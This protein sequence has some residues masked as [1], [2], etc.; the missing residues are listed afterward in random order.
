[1]ETIDLIADKRTTKGNGPAGRLRREGLVPAV[2]YG[3]KMA[4]EM[5]SVNTKTLE[6][7]LKQS[8]VGQVLLNLNIDNQDK[9]TVMIKELQTDP[10]TRDLMHVDFYE[11]DMNQKIR[12]K[13]PVVPVGKSKGV[14][15]GGM[16]QVIRRE[17]EVLCFPAD[18][19]ESIE[20][21]VSEL[22]IGESIHVE[23]IPLGEDMEIP[24]DVNFTVITVL[25]PKLAEE[26]KEVEEGEE[27]EEE[28]AEEV[29]EA[30]EE[31]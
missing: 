10:V 1:M 14:E 26:E 25:S 30:G 27:G 19:P 21:D 29:A 28:A 18:I 6:K 15:M 11:I 24:A 7:I 2:I 20:L 17:L 12:V 3:P 31:D 9:R 22:D 5:L 13:V 23:E 8:S 4:P 16:L